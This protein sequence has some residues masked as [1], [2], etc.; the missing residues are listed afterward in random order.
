MEILADYGG[1]NFSEFKAALVDLSVAQLGPI[2]GEM[3]RLM[4]DHAAIDAILADGSER[5]ESLASE[6]LKSVKDI[7]G[8]VRR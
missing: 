7:I 6:T 1:R 3:K 8:F 4:G 5:A 2:G